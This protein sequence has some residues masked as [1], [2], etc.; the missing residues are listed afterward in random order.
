MDVVCPWAYIGK[1]RMERAVADLPGVEVVWRPYRIDPAAPVPAEPLAEALRDPMADDLLRACS[2][3]LT[4]A[5]NRE[6][7]ARIAA[8]E[9]LGPTWGAAWRANS[10][11]AH[12]LIA[13]AEPYGVQDAVVEA[14]LK[15][16]W[17]D[18]AD[19]SDRAVLARVVGDVFPEGPA[20]LETDAGDRRVRDLLLEG[21]ARGIRTS[22]TIV[23]GERALAGAQPPE[24]IADFLA[25]AEEPR[26]LPEEV[27]RY[28]WAESLLDQRDP[29]GALELLQPLLAEHG[30]DRAVRLLAA[31]AWYASAQL[32]KARAALEE[33]VA[34]HPDDAYA[35]ALLGRTLQRMSEH[36]L[37][38]PHLRLGSAMG[39]PV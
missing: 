29:L 38:E 14:L 11:D 22:P 21:K 37:A 20:L 5:G 2:P 26:E 3:G 34:E 10:H 35:H 32:R 31:R 12:R 13:L 33:F 7:V 17:I 6:R 8:E 36:E 1:R 24:V 25:D 9:G 15:A 18:G 4:P 39:T 28:R 16:H 23:A 19:I 27:S 30:R